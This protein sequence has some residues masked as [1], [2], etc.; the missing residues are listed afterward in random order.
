MQCESTL[1]SWPKQNFDMS[2]HLQWENAHHI[3][4]RCVSP[5]WPQTVPYFPFPFAMQPFPSCSCNRRL[6]LKRHLQAKRLRG[7]ILPMPQGAMPVHAVLNF[8]IFFYKLIW[9]QLSQGE[10]SA[11]NWREQ[12]RIGENRIFHDF[13][14]ELDMHITNFSMHFHGN[15]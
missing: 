14:K 11:E 3:C 7:A 12:P 9:I 1:F 5:W 8:F 6:V 13:F 4:L 10:N 15:N 2:A